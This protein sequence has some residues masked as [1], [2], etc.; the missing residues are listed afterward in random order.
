MY[1][2]RRMRRG[3]PDVGCA[4]D[5]ATALS[6]VGVFGVPWFLRACERTNERVRAGNE[7]TELASGAVFS[8]CPL[9]LALPAALARAA[10][11]AALRMSINWEGE[12]VIIQVKPNGEPCPA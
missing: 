12:A 3:V 11:L 8:R 1:V 6:A 9:L 4:G 7:P 2:I 10:F 5:P